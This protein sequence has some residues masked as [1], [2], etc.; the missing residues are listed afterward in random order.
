MFLQGIDVE[1]EYAIQELDKMVT[2][3]GIRNDINQK[4]FR[5]AFEQNYPNPFNPTTVINYQLPV[6]SFV[7]LKVYDVLGNEVVVLVNKEKQPGNYE[8]EFQSTVS[9]RQLASG[10]YFYAIQVN[11]FDGSKNFRKVKKMMLLK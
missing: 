8:V 3:I 5:Y 1:L 11:A 9:N 2:A 7:T 6:Y 10:I 4:P